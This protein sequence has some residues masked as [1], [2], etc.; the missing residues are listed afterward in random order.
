MIV[1]WRLHTRQVLV[2]GGGTVAAGRIVAAL[3]ADGVVTVVAPEATP[4]IRQR[5]ERG[6]VT[7]RPRR[8]HPSDLDQADLVLTA[9]DDEAQSAWIAKACRGLRIPVNV[10][11]V[12][13]LCDFWFASMHRDGPVQ[14]A[15][16]TN[17][18]GPALSRRIRQRIAR[19]LPDRLGEASAAFGRLR[20]A[21]RSADPAPANA[22]R[23]MSWLT[24]L[25]THANW[26]WIANL[27]DSELAD[28][29]AR[30]LAGRPPPTA[31]PLRSA[32][33]IRLVG[34]GPGDPRWLTVAARDSLRDADLVLADRL[35]PD[36]ILDLVE[37][38]LRI[39]R[40]RKGNADEAQDSL[41]RQAIE[42]ARAGRVVVRLKCGDPFVF[43]RG[44]EEVARYRA[45]GLDAEV[46]PGVSSALAAPALAGIAT[47]HRGLAD[48]VLVCTGHGQGSRQPDVPA[49]RPDTTV[50]M[51]MAIGRLPTLSDELR[52]AGW[53]AD[54]PAAIV[55]RA[56]H[57]D[58][59][60]THTV[61]GG[62]ASTKAQAPGIL[63]IG[64][65][66]AGLD[67]LT[68]TATL[69]VG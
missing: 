30:Y 69:A 16:S 57:P 1:A 63:V 44:G 32:T 18:T 55:E 12:P 25:A 39:A 37:G 31:A 19:A 43:G 48:R 6:E 13:D 20:R 38:E 26:S 62:L 65:V 7:W 11:D 4:E 53:P 34:A 17:G 50:V 15:V 21:I 14:I 46:L 67:A 45:A 51:L 8:F 22:A 64:R 5:A 42:A 56:S 52:A 27:D 23:R 10:A 28:L 40:K 2:V 61:V 24:E 59:R 66:A 3:E 35:V 68:T 33:V 60:V 29:T 41:D 9:M 47:T 49:Y 36:A 58:Q 54:W